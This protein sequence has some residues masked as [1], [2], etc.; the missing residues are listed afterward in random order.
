MAECRNGQNEI[1]RGV[2]LSRDRLFLP[3]L[4]NSEIMSTLSNIVIGKLKSL[5]VRWGI[6]IRL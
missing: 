2:L 1:G 4:R 5:F 6:P 3:L